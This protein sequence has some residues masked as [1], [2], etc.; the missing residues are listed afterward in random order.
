MLLKKL[1]VSSSEMCKMTDG[2]ANPQYIPEGSI[3]STVNVPNSPVTNMRPTSN[4]PWRVPV[5]ENPEVTIDVTPQ[6]SQQPI[7][8]DR[9]VVTGN[10][11][12]VTIL[13]KD[14]PT[15]TFVAI[16]E[17]V[18]A[19]NPVKLPALTKLYEVKIVPVT[20][21]SINGTPA[22]TYDIQVSVHACFELEGQLYNR[23][24]LSD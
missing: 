11:K 23:V 3:S 19:T 12:T 10:V 22:T 9:V 13:G 24:H 14:T 17:D 21:L 16:V 7:I 6:D 20:P 4:E 15:G 18:D 5:S 1:S 2:M 8:V